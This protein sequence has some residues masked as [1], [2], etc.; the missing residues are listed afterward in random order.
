MKEGGGESVDDY[1]TGSLACLFAKKK[2]NLVFLSIFPV[3]IEIKWKEGGRGEKTLFYH[4][5]G[6]EHHQ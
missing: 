6:A 2:K 3:A 5:N 1:W 4:Q